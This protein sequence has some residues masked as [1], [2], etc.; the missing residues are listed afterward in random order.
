MCI[1]WASSFFLFEKN[2]RML[3]F[4][5]LFDSNYGLVK[6]LT[7]NEFNFQFEFN[8][9]QLDTLFWL[10][11]W[12][13]VWSTSFFSFYFLEICFATAIHMKFQRQIVYC[14]SIDCLSFISLIWTGKC[15]SINRRPYRYS[16]S[17]IC[18]AGKKHVFC[19]N[20]KIMPLKSCE[21]QC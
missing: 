9:M 7:V 21:I 5:H 4:I 15:S 13:A 6:V 16:H 20:S 10:V 19:F 3:D 2:P 11:D 1:S 8:G 17:G 14:R 18:T 12:M